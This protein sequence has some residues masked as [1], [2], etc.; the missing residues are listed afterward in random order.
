[1][2]LLLPPRC[3]PAVL[4]HQLSFYLL[5][6]NG[7]NI[8]SNDE[9]EN[10]STFAIGR[11]APFRPDGLPS[12]IFVWKHK[13][14]YDFQLGGIFFGRRNRFVRPAAVGMLT[15]MF[16]GDSVTSSVF[17]QL[18]S[19]LKQ[20]LYLL[21]FVVIIVIGNQTLSFVGSHPDRFIESILFSSIWGFL[22]VFLS[23]FFIFLME[24]TVNLCK[25]LRPRKQPRIKVDMTHLIAY[26]Q[27]KE[28]NTEDIIFILSASLNSHKDAKIILAKAEK[29]VFKGKRIINPHRLSAAAHKRGFSAVETTNL[30]MK[31]FNLTPEN[32]ATIWAK[33]T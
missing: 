26:L 7:G 21:I 9:S 16:I 30:L 5:D 2:K 6:S 15:G 12:G 32:A 11:W 20:S 13:D 24:H 14:N 4:K 18:R 28:L 25:R 33:S 31:F 10:V 27:E 3:L 29:R 23:R 1:M 19:R 22:C 8:K 17:G